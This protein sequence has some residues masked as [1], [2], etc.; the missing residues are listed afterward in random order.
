MAKVVIFLLLFVSNFSYGIEFIPERLDIAFTVIVEV[1][2]LEAINEHCR[3]EFDFSHVNGVIR[4]CALFQSGICK[5]IVP[6]PTV[7][8]VPDEIVNDWGH[9]IMHCTYGLYHR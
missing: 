8:F 6:I 3:E 2:P 9:E 5:I 7:P 4:A 1:Y